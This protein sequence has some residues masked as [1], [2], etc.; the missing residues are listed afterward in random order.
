M[1]GSKGSSPTVLILY[2]KKMSK[3]LQERKE[4]WA[5]SFQ[6]LNLFISTNILDTNKIPA[7]G[8]N[9]ICTVANWAF[10]V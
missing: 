1:W 10:T 9:N 6:P 3:D 8:F 2:R 5:S 7:A 4:K